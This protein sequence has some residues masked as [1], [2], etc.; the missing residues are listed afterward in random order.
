MRASRLAAWMLVLLGSAGI[1][2]GDLD[3]HSIASLMGHFAALGRLSAKIEV[4]EGPEWIP[5][6]KALKPLLEEPRVRLIEAIDQAI[7][8]G[9]REELMGALGVYVGLVG[10][11]KEHP[12]P[13]YQAPLL[14]LLAKD[15]LRQRTYTDTVAGALRLYPSRE[16]AVA[17]MDVAERAPD[18]R[19]RKDYIDS[20]AALL[21]ISLPIAN[22]TPPLRQEKILSDFEAWFSRNKDR[23]RFDK[24]GNFR[25]AGGEASE[26]RKGLSGDDRARIRQDPVCVLRLLDTTMSDDLEDQVKRTRVPDLNAQCGAALWGPDGAAFMAKAAAG[27]KVEEQKSI[28]MEA[29]G[30][31]LA[32]RY[33]VFEAALLAS[34]YVV[35][36]E[37]DPEA[38]KLAKEV[39]IQFSPSDVRK[40]AKDEPA[41]VRK[42]AEGFADQTRE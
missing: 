18:A 5:Y 40:A 13:A 6:E 31:S 1:S 12:N 37:Q 17:Y 2:R 28:E 22:N 8:E 15:D 38:L 29:E 24:H 36:Y 23:I 30:A 20:T 32:G 25:L 26:E 35:A 4:Q 21:H 41:S 39:L 33:P 7:R 34:V 27:D 9:T 14:Q 16:T 42:K 11:K 10:I 3:R 19:M